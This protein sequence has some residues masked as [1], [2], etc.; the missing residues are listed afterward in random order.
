MGH[1]QLAKRP[2]NK[3][4]AKEAKACVRAVPQQCRVWVWGWGW[5]GYWSGY[6]KTAPTWC[7]TIAVKPKR[8]MPATSPG[9]EKARLHGEAVLQLLPVADQATGTATTIGQLLDASSCALPLICYIAT[10]CP[11][12][13][14]CHPASTHSNLSGTSAFPSVLCCV[15]VVGV[16]GRFA[17]RVQPHLGA[18]AHGGADVLRGKYSKCV[19][20]TLQCVQRLVTSQQPQS[21]DSAECIHHGRYRVSLPVRALDLRATGRHARRE[22]HHQ[23]TGAPQSAGTQRATVP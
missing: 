12:P 9:N 4:L 10:R 14:Q 17:H 5:W 19:L 15:C 1:H 6:P 21:A 3:F 23:G 13:T 8:R 22:P 2:P 7:R 16:A 11:L 20:Q 18:W